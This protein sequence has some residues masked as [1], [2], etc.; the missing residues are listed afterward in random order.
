MQKNL[1]IKPETAV[2]ADLSFGA[3]IGLSF[4]ILNEMSGQ[5][6]NC[7]PQNSGQ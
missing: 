3:I 4:L 7:L 2:R 6:V 5:R 1:Q